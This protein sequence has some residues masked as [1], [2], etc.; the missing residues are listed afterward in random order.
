MIEVTR[1]AARPEDA[2]SL[3]ELRVEAMRPSLEAIGRFDPLRARKRF[4]DSFRCDNTTRLLV[5]D[6]LVGFYATEWKEGFLW[7]NHLYIC[8]G[9][10]SRGI[11]GSVIHEL[12]QYAV[13]RAL[14]I[15][16]MALKGSRS[17]V[18]YQHQ[19]FSLIEVLEFDNVYEWSKSPGWNGVA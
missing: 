14:T 5:E 17:N 8:P 11:A 1:A 6:K 15:R 19:G 18:F 9:F 10:Q 4:L 3:A 16:L 2:V 7:L 12:K 13:D